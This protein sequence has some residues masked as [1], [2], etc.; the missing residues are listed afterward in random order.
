M[1]M[2]AVY[3]EK[4]GYYPEDTVHGF[5]YVRLGN[6]LDIR[7]ITMNVRGVE[8][9]RIGSGEDAIRSSNS[10]M[11]KRFTVAKPGPL[12]AGI[13]QYPF[14]FT[15][16]DTL[17][18]TYGGHYANVSF[19]AQAS[20]DIK[21]AFDRVSQRAFKVFYHPDSV[22]ELTGPLSFDSKL[23]TFQELSTTLDPD[24]EEP[25]TFTVNID[26]CVLFTGQQFNG[27]VSISNPS[28]KTI[29]KVHLT[30]KGVESVTTST[31]KETNLPYGISLERDVPVRKSKVIDKKKFTFDVDKDWEFIDVPFSIVVPNEGRT[32]FQGVFSK[33]EWF[34]ECRVNVALSADAKGKAMIAV[35]RRQ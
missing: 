32:T 11:N 1:R 31:V 19:R 7:R 27:T 24:E 33:Y 20:F 3:L 30:L 29:R 34:L 28:M 4:P 17:L 22:K 14:S 35:Y 10:L 18:P 13:Y 26:N 6:G 21:N 5:V 8:N 9:I 12:R 2:F 25:T 23:T 16:L 15:L